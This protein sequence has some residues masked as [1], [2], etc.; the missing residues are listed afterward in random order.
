MGESHD[1]IRDEFERDR[2]RVNALHGERGWKVKDGSS[3]E[4][5]GGVEVRRRE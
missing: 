4:C 3:E 5:K 2:E 1:S